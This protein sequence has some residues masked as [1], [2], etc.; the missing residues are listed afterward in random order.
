[1]TVF[2]VGGEDTFRP[3]HDMELVNREKLAHVD[4]YGAFL[5]GNHGYVEIS[6]S[7][8]GRVLVVKD[9]YANSFVPFLTENYETIGVVDFRNFPYGLD[10]MIESREYDEIILLYSF[11]NF[12]ED[13][14]VIYLN[15]PSVSR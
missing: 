3:L 9:S 14:Y 2:E 11:Y 12:M 6:G 15:R 1:M 8:T 13:N 10:R 7:G 5:D 4:K